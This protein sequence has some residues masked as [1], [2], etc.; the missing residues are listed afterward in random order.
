MAPNEKEKAHITES[1]PWDHTA[2]GT[3][4]MTGGAAVVGEMTDTE[5]EGHP[6]GRCA[7]EAENGEGEGPGVLLT[8][9][10]QAATVPYPADRVPECGGRR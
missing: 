9:P 3:I 5:G 6:R 1:V 2:G 7:V 10:G 4:T 8:D